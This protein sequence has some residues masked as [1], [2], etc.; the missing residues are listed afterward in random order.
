M[1]NINILIDD[2]LKLAKRELT[3]TKNSVFLQVLPGIVLFCHR[4]NTFDR[5][6]I[7]HDLAEQDDIRSLVSIFKLAS[8][9]ALAESCLNIQTQIRANQDILIH[10]YSGLVKILHDNNEANHEIDHLISKSIANNKS[11]IG[12]YGASLEYYLG[13]NEL[14]LVQPA[15]SGITNLEYLLAKLIFIN[16]KIC[17]Y[18]ELSL[19]PADIAINVLCA[20][21]S[22]DGNLVAFLDSNL[23][24]NTTTKLVNSNPA[25]SYIYMRYK[26][27]EHESSQSFKKMLVEN[28]L[29]TSLVYIRTDRENPWILLEICPNNPDVLM[30]SEDFYIS[31]AKKSYIQEV[32]INQIAELM[33]SR[34]KTNANGIGYVD[35]DTCKSLNY[36]LDPVASIN[37]SPKLPDTQQV[38]LGEVCTLFRGPQLYTKDINNSSESLYLVSQTAVSNNDFSS[39]SLVAIDSE[40]YNNNLQFKLQPGDILLLSRST[41]NKV[42]IVPDNIPNCIINPNVIC[43]RPDPSKINPEYLYLLLN[44]RYGKS[45]IANIEKGT[46]LKSISISQLKQL[47]LNISTQEKQF[48]L[49]AEYRAIQEQYQQ[50]KTHFEEFL[51]NVDL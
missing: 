40:T 47:V 38:V 1:N 11:S 12:I 50:A 20:R 28:K 29:L 19:L 6:I 9:K 30:I 17:I 34:N 10:L 45:L 36:T 7:G 13:F 32:H 26:A 2:I 31:G 39:E 15:K 27:F 42:A 16:K 35:I 43:I 14:H 44:S 3:D 49:S 21:K 5:I 46:V 51:S 48:Q 22:D 18:S 41:T 8:F 37:Y 4:K 33:I 25:K 24:I 23:E